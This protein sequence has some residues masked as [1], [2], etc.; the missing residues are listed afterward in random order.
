MPEEAPPGRRTAQRMGSPCSRYA[1]LHPERQVDEEIGT[2]ITIAVGGAVFLVED[3]VPARLDFDV[4]AQGIGG[5]H[6]EHPVAAQQYPVLDV[7]VPL[8][9]ELVFGAD[10]QRPVALFGAE[11]VYLPGPLRQPAARFA[12]AR[13]VVARVQEIGARPQRGVAVGLFP[14]EG[15]AA[16][17][18]AFGVHGRAVEIGVADVAVDQVAHLVLEDRQAQARRIRFI[19]EPGFQVAGFFGLEIG[20][21]LEASP[22]AAVVGVI[23]VREC[24]RAETRA[25]RHPDFPVFR[26][27]EVIGQPARRLVSIRRDVVVAQIGLQVVRAEVAAVDQPGGVGVALAAGVAAGMADPLFQP[28]QQRAEV[29]VGGELE[30]VLPRVGPLQRG[31][32][33]AP[34]AVLG[35]LLAEPEAQHAVP[36]VGKPVGA[37]HGVY[38]LARQGV[39]LFRIVADVHVGAYVAVVRGHAQVVAGLPAVSQ[40][41][42]ESVQV[43]A[44]RVAVVGVGTGVLVGRVEAVA[45]RYVA[46]NRIVPAVLRPRDARAGLDGAVAA[47]AHVRP[48]ARGPVA[49]LGL[50]RDDV[51][52]A[53]HGVGTIQAAGGAAQDLDAFYGSRVDRRP[54]RGAA[55][56]TVHA[57]AVHQHQGLRRAGAAQEYAGDGLRAAVGVELDVMVPRQDFGHAALAGALELALVDDG[58]VALHVLLRLGAAAGGHDDGIQPADGLLGLRHG[59]GQGKETGEDGKR[60]PV[61]DE[62]H[63]RP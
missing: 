52:D 23:Q 10:R 51:D 20:I 29:L 13:P 56:G 19:A 12:G 6:V 42:A 28:L 22:R 17:R 59:A 38:L 34:A 21:P 1:A 50:V 25:A 31:E 32:P 18:R 11:A 53:A 46:R 40:A 5:R 2:R 8:A 63:D 55:D 39:G 43:I 41:R 61:Q 30:V 49:A 24:G 14:R 36:A 60:L 48:G 7:A 54:V 26:Q 4:L 9:G 44:V 37:G 47:D 33:R 57:Y 35:R 45:A 16:Y 3:V 27:V 58:D 15:D 62:R